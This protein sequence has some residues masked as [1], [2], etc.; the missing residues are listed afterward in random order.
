MAD[1]LKV[2]RRQLREACAAWQSG[3]T[4]GL[5]LWLSKHKAH[6]TTHDYSELV[7]LVRV[8][9]GDQTDYSQEA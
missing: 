9:L 4:L 2:S 1:D 6:F 8:E 5:G 3:G 7:G